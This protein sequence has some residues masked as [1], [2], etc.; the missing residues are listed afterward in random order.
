MISYTATIVKKEDI[1]K[2]LEALRKLGL[3]AYVLQWANNTGSD[4]IVFDK[5]SE[6]SHQ[7]FDLQIESLDL[8]TKNMLKELNLISNNKFKSMIKK[9]RIIS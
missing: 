9:D 5:S 4:F 6:H 1:Y 2:F 7:F 3:N 8:Y